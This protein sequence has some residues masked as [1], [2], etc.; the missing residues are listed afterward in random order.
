MAG[1]TI[2]SNLDFKKA[3]Y[4][5][6]IHPEH[7]PKTAIITPFELFEFVRMSIILKYAAQ[8]FQRFINKVF[9]GLCFCFVY[10][11]EIL[12]AFENEEEH[13]KHLFLVFQRLKQFGLTI[14]IERAFLGKNM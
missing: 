13:N 10:I 14:N 9:T 7:I 8:S 3:Y 1:K 11:N 12:I 5:I 6:P 4:Q 2:F